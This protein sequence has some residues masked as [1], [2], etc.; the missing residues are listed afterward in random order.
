MSGRNERPPPRQAQDAGF[1]HSASRSQEVRDHVE[2]RLSPSFALIL[3]ILASP[4]HAAGPRPVLKPVLEMTSGLSPYDI[5]A[6]VH[7]GALL[8]GVPWG[9]QRLASGGNTWRGVDGLGPIHQLAASG[10]DLWAG[11]T[12][13]LFQSQ[14][15]GRHWQAV[16]VEGLRPPVWALLADSGRIWA[17]TEDQLFVTADGGVVWKDV[18]LPPEA[19]RIQSLA[20]HPERP[21]MLVAGCL[22]G[23]LLHTQDGGRTWTSQRLTTHPN[24][25]V[26][27]ARIAPRLFAS[28]KDGLF[29]REDGGT[30]WASLAT[31]DG[32]DLGWTFGLLQD[33]LAP[34]TLYAGTWHGVLRSDDGGRN[35]TDASAG[36]PQE[37][38]VRSLILDPRNPGG[39]LAALDN[40]GVWRSQD[41]A[42][43]WTP[44]Q[45]P[46]RAGDTMD[47]L[48]VDAA[49]PRRMAMGSTFSGVFLS[50]DGGTT[51]APASGTSGIATPWA[52]HFLPGGGLIVGTRDG[53]LWRQKEPHAPWR[54]SAIQGGLRPAW[55]KG[56]LQHGRF[57]YACTRYGL[58]KSPDGGVSWV[59]TGLRTDVNQILVDPS[60]GRH[61][62]AACDFGGV[63]ETRNGGRTWSRPGGKVLRPL[64]S[65][66]S[67]AWDPASPGAFFVGTVS[68]AYRFSQGRFRP[69]DPQD[70]GHCSLV[71]TT[72]APEH[73]LFAVRERRLQLSQDGGAS[74][75]ILFEAPHHGRDILIPDPARPGAFW[76]AAG[77]TLW[78]L[79]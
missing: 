58:F 75:T 60:N 33:P 27:V 25:V 37:R 32:A 53:D 5:L 17:A 70:Y 34:A 11:G 12:K 13:G 77:S 71:R 6:D 74:W 51:W 14:D 48:A 72:D 24:G 65:V 55:I 1:R 45:L 20:A 78:R 10:P 56:F 52:I 79:E 39:L 22:S 26:H 40:G 9:L 8:A 69:L 49:D 38:M 64:A 4:L 3:F 47:A 35:W 7:S 36:L 19:G 31:E 30:S 54:R 43:T 46:W 23:H 2:M 50:E 41:R 16:R 73:R 66:K 28:T 18:P 68:G 76:F 57:L 15:G 59:R 67:L 42:G 29:T 63:M 62:L 44:C 21:E 61:L